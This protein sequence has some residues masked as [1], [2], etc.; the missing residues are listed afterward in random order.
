MKLTNTWIA[1]LSLLIIALFFNPFQMNAQNKNDKKTFILIHGS[2][3]S[4]WN[5]YKVTPLLE[6]Q[7]HIVYSI[8]LP[9]MGRDKTPIENVRFDSTIQQLCKLIDSI[10]GKVILVAHSKNGIFNSQ[11]AELRPNKIEKLI[12]LAAVLV[13]NGKCAKDYFALDEKEVLG[14]HITY[15][16][17]ISSMLLPEIYKEGLYHDCPDDITQMA[18]IILLPE[19]TESAKAKLKLTEGN[20][21]NVPRYYIECTEDRAITPWLQEKMLAEMPCLKV[22]KIASS[23]SPFFSM[24]DK[25]TEIINEISKL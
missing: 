24:P 7:G 16:G 19:S 13:A 15:N 3:H 21:G 4:A 2:W 25:L 11:L 10:P 20:Y 17:T 22:Y 6:K 14:G 23:H 1:Y 12:Y 5:W 9:G 8:D 18:N